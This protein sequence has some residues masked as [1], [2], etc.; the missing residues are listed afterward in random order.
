MSKW[1]H[2]Y[3]DERKQQ[4]VALLSSNDAHFIDV[5]V[6]AFIARHPLYSRHIDTI[7]KH[8]KLTWTKLN[9]GLTG[10]NLRQF[11]DSNLEPFVPQHVP[12][13][14]P[15]QHL[16]AIAAPGTE[17]KKMTMKWILTSNCACLFGKAI[18]AATHIHRRRGK[19]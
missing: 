4:V 1:I 6:G 8:R 17:D 13:A 5:I 10:T 7:Q 15:L 19:P 14:I 16:Q 3:L 2:T 9:R 11:E 12:I 18:E